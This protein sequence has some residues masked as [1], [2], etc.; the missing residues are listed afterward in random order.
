MTEFARAWD[1]PLGPDG[2]APAEFAVQSDGITLAGE[3][4][5]EGPPIVLLHGL[6]AARRYVVHGSKVLPRRGLLAIAYDARGHG[7]SQGPG[8][9]GGYGYSELAADLGAVL[10]AQA[11]EG[12]VVLAGHSMGAHTAAAFALE[13]PDRVAALVAI[14]PAVIGTPPPDETLEEWDALADALER[15]GVEGFVAAV[16]RD[17]DGEWRER[18]QRFSRERM[19]VHRDL[20]AVARAL[21]EVPRSLPFDGI[22]ELE[23][24]E[25]P[26]LVV[27][28]RDEADPGHPHAVAEAW[29]ER[30]PQAR[31]VAEEEG[32]A[33]LAWQG[34][35]LSREIAAFVEEPAVRRRLES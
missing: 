29:A 16:G 5:G 30:L 10:D 15:E 21:R 34:G 20:S 32:S 4:L 27:A 35:K 33:P 18:L 13:H 25:V 9:E 22:G 6:S 2:P 1:G 26:A 7:S 23:F 11:A 31:L 3:L 8:A 12:R 17:L 19:K 24:L 28:S 14:G